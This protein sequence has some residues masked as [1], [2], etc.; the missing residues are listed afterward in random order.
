MLSRATNSLARPREPSQKARGIDYRK[1]GSSTLIVYSL[2]FPSLMC[3]VFELTPAKGE[4]NGESLNRLPVLRERT[5]S[6][7]VDPQTF[8][9]YSIQG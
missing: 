3:D 1:L 7:R 9:A 6:V 5:H 2:Q 8:V 4:A